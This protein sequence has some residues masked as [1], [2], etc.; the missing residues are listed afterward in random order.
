MSAAGFDQAR[1]GARGVP[2][3]AA[4]VDGGVA[5][6][7]VPGLLRPRGI[8]GSGSRLM[9]WFVVAAGA[10][11]AAAGVGAAAGPRTPLGIRITSPLGRTGLSGPIRL[12]AQTH[13]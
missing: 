2:G 5:R 11:I 9:R 1:A 4:H 6:R 10:A 3:S 13:G 7:R 12:V 8:V